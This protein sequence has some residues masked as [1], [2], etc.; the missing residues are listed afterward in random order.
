M[1]YPADPGVGNSTAD[2][3]AQ[4]LPLAMSRIE[5]T[6]R[7]HTHRGAHGGAQQ[8]AIF[9]RRRPSR[10]HFA[11]VKRFHGLS[12]PGCRQPVGN[13]EVASVKVV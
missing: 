12:L 6:K 4:Q 9:R 8:L 2:T 1:I 11:T 5:R 3:W 13:P 10:W 7:R